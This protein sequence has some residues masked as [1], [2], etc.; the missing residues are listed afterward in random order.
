MSP[1]HVFICLLL[2]KV[3]SQCDMRNRADLPAIGALKYFQCYDISHQDIISCKLVECHKKIKLTI[4][5]FSSIHYAFFEDSQFMI[6]A[7]HSWPLSAS[8]LE[9]E[10]WFF[11]CFLSSSPLTNEFYFPCFRFDMCGVDVISLGYLDQTDISIVVYL[12]SWFMIYFC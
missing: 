7:L 4:K 12:K 9:V 10:I 1:S 5:C 3:K 6:T 8:E 2:S 11:N